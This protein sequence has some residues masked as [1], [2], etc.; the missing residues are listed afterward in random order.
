MFQKIGLVA[1][2]WF[3]LILLGMGC[4]GT[5]KE[6]APNGLEFKG[7]ETVSGTVTYEGQPLSYGAVLFFHPEKSM[8]VTTGKM[9]AVTF[10]Q[11]DEE[12]K[13]T[14]VGVPEGPVM[15]C[16]V[17]DPDQ[18][19]MDLTTPDQGGLP[20]MDGGP[21]GGPGGPGLPPGG[22]GL[23]PGGPGMPPVGPGVGLGNPVVE[24]LSDAQKKILKNVHQTYGQTMAPLI[25]LEVPA[26]G[27]TFNIELPLKGLKATK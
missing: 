1:A 17:C 25:S 2:S 22:P 20:G 21:P 13:Y 19:I 5:P 9:T 14:A 26:G 3:I 16:I 6:E 23:P 4:D 18:S 7:N 15:I 11:L 27:K 10:A 12:G 8:D 24:K